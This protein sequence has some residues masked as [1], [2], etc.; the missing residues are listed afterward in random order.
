MKLHKLLL[1]AAIAGL[2]TSVGCASTRDQNMTRTS[3]TRAPAEVS[4]EAERATSVPQ[5]KPIY[6]EYDAWI[7]SDDARGALRANAKLIQKHPEWGVLTIEGHCDERGSDEYN[8]ALGQQR[9]A[10]AKRYMVDL[11]VPASRFATVSFGE[12]RPALEGHDE[13]AW[14]LNRRGVLALEERHVSHP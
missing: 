12:Y 8:V 2:A 11:G 4:I 6:F 13:A 1:W 5:L 9:A 14:R 7:L 10:A 3:E